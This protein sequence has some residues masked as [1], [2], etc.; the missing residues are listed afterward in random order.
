MIMM[1]LVTF[2]AEKRKWTFSF[3]SHLN[4]KTHQVKFSQAASNEVDVQ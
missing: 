2:Q 3:S 4:L 1:I